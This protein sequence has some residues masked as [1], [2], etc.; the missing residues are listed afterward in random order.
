MIVVAGPPG[1]GKTSRFPLSSFGIDWFNADERAAELNPGSFRGIPTEIRSRVNLEFRQWILHHI[2][3]RKSFAIETTLRSLI[4]FQHSRLAYEHGYWTAMDYI[5]PGSV[6]ESIRRIIERS[7]RG[8]H[9]ASERLVREIYDK[10]MMNLFTALDFD[11][12]RI[13]VV[14]I[15]DNSELGG[16]VRQL[17]SF[18]RGRPLWVAAEIPAWV[19][20]LFRG[21]SFEVATL[22]EAVKARRQ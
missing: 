16:R 10:S 2:R 17:L 22:R 7:Y 12:S 3:A 19:E 4:T 18:R 20:S 15:Y 11:E 6:E 1:S 14:R 21:T 9:S 8:G 13:E 5:A